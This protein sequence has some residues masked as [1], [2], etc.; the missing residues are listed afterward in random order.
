MS[1]NM[2][3]QKL[4][5]SHD[6]IAGNICVMETPVKTQAFSLGTDRKSRDNRYLPSLVAMPQDGCLSFRRPC[7]T[8]MRDKKTAAFIEEDKMGVKSFRLFLYAASDTASSG[9]WQLR[10]SLWL[11][12]LASDNSTPTLLKTA[13][14]DLGDKTPQNTFESPPLHGGWSIGLSHILEH[15]VLSEA[16]WLTPFSDRERVWEG[17]QKQAWET[18]L[19]P[20]SS[21]APV[22]IE[23]QNLR[24]RR[25]PPL[26]LLDSCPFAATGWRVGVASPIAWGFQMVSYIIVYH[27]L[28]IIS[29]IYA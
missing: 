12:V 1:R 11:A 24:R 22:S 20:L 3:Q 23:R 18:V 29:I 14:N 26:P 2:T 15:E 5:K 19:R 10:L 6:L 21:D 28:G 25:L 7:S 4:E 16:D 9:E 17:G 27:I 13:I 8:D